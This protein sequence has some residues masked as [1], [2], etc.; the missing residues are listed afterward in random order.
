MNES[1]EKIQKVIDL[2][3]EMFPAEYTAYG[4]QMEA[5]RETN[6]NEFAAGTGD[7]YINQLA[8]RIP[9]TLDNLFKSKL[10][11]EEYKYI[12]DVKE[13][14]EWFGR[15]WKEFSPATKI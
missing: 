6:M 9:L 4:K 5:E 10:S 8:H 7:N 2:Y 12:F 1:K 14:A 15:T 3:K 13:G 11:D